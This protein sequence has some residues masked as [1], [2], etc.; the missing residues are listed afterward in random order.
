MKPASISATSAAPDP[1]LETLLLPFRSG[2]LQWPSAPAAVLFLRARTGAALQS[3]AL[4]AQQREQLLCVQS[5]KPDAEALR[6]DQLRVVAQLTQLEAVAHTASPS[7]AGTFPLVML[8][9]P[10]TRAE[11]RAL[12]ACGLQQTA[13]GGV[14]LCCQANNAGARSGESDLARLA[15]DSTAVRSLSKQKCRVYWLHHEPARIDAALLAEW[16]AL[17]APLAIDG[18]Q[19]GPLF[20]RP[21]LFSW[22]HVD[23]ASALLARCLPDDLGGRGA[24]LGAGAGYLSLA[25]LQRC[26][27]VTSMDLYEAEARALSLA[28]QNLAARSSANSSEGKPAAA[29]AALDFLWHDV[30]TGLPADRQYDFIISNPPFHHSRSRADAPEIGQA[31]LLAAARG[32]RPGGRFWLVANRHLAYENL[33]RQHFRQVR[34]ICSEQGF[35]VIEAIK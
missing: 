2:E 3:P 28:Q 13:P 23:P 17:D 18:G 15:A 9:P 7:A 35:K 1:V 6:A 33:L 11:A 32:L 26:A 16:L 14:L 10:R 24:D 25:V 20:S 22:A 21:G 8:L 30:S 12:L 19:L 5:F 31:F 29:A 27:A 4:S 34:E